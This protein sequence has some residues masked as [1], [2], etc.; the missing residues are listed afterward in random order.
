MES[1]HSRHLFDD[2]LEEGR[3]TTS[4]LLGLVDYESRANEERPPFYESFLLR[5]SRHNLLKSCIGTM[6]ESSTAS[7][8]TRIKEQRAH[9]L[10]ATQ[11]GRR[12]LTSDRI[13]VVI[14]R[15]WG[16]LISMDRMLAEL[17]SGVIDGE[18]SVLVCDPSLPAVMR[19]VKSVLVGKNEKL[20][21]L[22]AMQQYSD[23]GFMTLKGASRTPSSLR[24]A[25]ASASAQRVH[26]TYATPVRHLPVQP[27]CTATAHAYAAA[28]FWVRRMAAQRSSR[29]LS[30]VVELLCQREIRSD[31]K[32]LPAY[33]NS[34]TGSAL[35]LSEHTPVKEAVSLTTLLGVG[36]NTG[37]LDNDGDGSMDMREAVKFAS[38]VMRG[39]VS[40]RVMPVT[41]AE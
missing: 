8:L 1:V 18:D 21:V 14:D 20:V 33:R 32:V 25:S 13:Y 31:V 12:P 17:A 11:R 27:L 38:N 39:N 3:A 34:V 10:E 26:G 2:R 29:F 30:D 22:V 36:R 19:S 35:S 23:N 37:L 9:A 7:A 4:S 5:L 41:P 24:T 28:P 6:F 15:M 40:V 16:Q